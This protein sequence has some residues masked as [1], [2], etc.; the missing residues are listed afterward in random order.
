MRKLENY[1]ATLTLL[2]LGTGED[3]GVSDK[4]LDLLKSMSVELLF[5]IFRGA[6]VLLV[7]VIASKKPKLSAERVGSVF[8]NR[9]NHDH[10]LTD[11]L[12]ILTCNLTAVDYSILT[13]KTFN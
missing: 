9:I 10:I 3:S 7:L 6:F 12:T 1:P 13:L 5:L 4:L 11:T 8:I 2:G